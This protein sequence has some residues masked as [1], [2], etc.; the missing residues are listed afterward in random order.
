MQQSCN[1]RPNGKWQITRRETE[2]LYLRFYTYNSGEILITN[3]CT[4][5][6]AAVRTLSAGRNGRA[7]GVYVGRT[8]K[9]SDITNE[10]LVVTSHWCNLSL[11]NM[12]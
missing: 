11:L 1:S 3:F 4:L 10:R 5:I 6:S 8:W 9:Q 12:H 7:D 2:V